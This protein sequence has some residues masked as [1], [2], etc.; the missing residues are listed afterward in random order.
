[1]LSYFLLKTLNFCY[2]I[3]KNRP[4][5]V[6]SY[7]FFTNIIVYI[8]T[9]F[10]KTTPLGSIRSSYSYSVKHSGKILASLCFRYPRIQISN[11][12]S[13]INKLSEVSF[14]KPKKTYLVNNVIDEKIFNYHKI[15]EKNG[16]FR[17]IGVGSLVEVKRW[18]ILLKV[19]KKLLEENI[20]FKVDIFGD[21]PEFNNLQGFINKY[22]LQNCCLINKSRIDIY[23]EIIKSNVL[24]HT[25]DDEGCSNVI[26]EAMSIGRPVISTRT[27]DAS[28]MIKN[29]EN[30]FLV[31]RDDVT[32]ITK[33]VLELFYDRNLCKKM[34]D[35]G[36]QVAKKNYSIEQFNISISQVFNETT[37]R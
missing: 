36:S 27:G 8:S 10:F 31:N 29:G 16:V 5:I 13:V 34:G 37:Q 32:S 28:R 19:A 7:S 9:R 4:K 35:F 30:G 17:I 14:W 2:I 1:M 12:Y 26:L 20:L 23:N 6:F 18:D 21:G 33:A 25:S 24:I 22:D 3:H 15:P 11:N